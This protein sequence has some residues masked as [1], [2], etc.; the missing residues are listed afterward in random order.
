MTQYDRLSK[1]TSYYVNNI[2]LFVLWC[3]TLKRIKYQFVQPNK[4]IHV[5]LFR[6]INDFFTH[7]FDSKENFIFIYENRN[8]QNFNINQNN[9]YFFAFLE[10]W[11]LYRLQ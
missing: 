9:E 7:S 10:P 3:F 5:Y 6:K 4:K 8:Q 11:L 1:E 2:S